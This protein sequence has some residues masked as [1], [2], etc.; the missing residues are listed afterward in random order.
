MAEIKQD[1]ESIVESLEYWGLE[2]DAGKKLITVA[3]DPSACFEGDP[4][5]MIR[6]VRFAAELG[7]DIHIK[8]YNAILDKSALLSEANTDDI[9][10]EFE[11]LLTAEFAGKGLKILAGAE[12]MPYIIGSL[13]ENMTKRAMSQFAVLAENIDKTMRVR[14]R[15]IALFYLCFEKKAALGAV[16]FL[17][18]SPK[19][20]ARIADA[21]AMLEPMCFLGNEYEFKRFVALCGEERY[22]YLD[23]LSKAQRIVYDMPDTKILSRHHMMEAIKSKGDPIFIED[24]EIDAADIA[25]SNIAE[26]EKAADILR[27]LLDHVHKNPK[28]NTR[29]HLLRQAE[30]YA[31][32]ALRVP[33]QKVR[34]LK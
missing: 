31:K 4:L 28:M 32:A 16:K 1:K 23:S 9:R 29:E 26:G 19:M 21:F 3:G 30:K 15:R 8:A 17:N 10:V 34:R 33:F 6:I 25:G 11:R 14:E 18:Y 12:L 20:E 13:A 7:F 2:Q 5:M 27:E 24:L 22:R